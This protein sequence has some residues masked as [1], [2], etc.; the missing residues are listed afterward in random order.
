MKKKVFS[1]LI[2]DDTIPDIYNTL[3]NVILT[4][5]QQTG[6]AMEKLL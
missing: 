6:G 2:D 4:T 5:L 1:T 3:C